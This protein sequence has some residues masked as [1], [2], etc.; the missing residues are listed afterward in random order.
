MKI[1]I[2]GFIAVL[3]LPV[4]GCEKITGNA[5]LLVFSNVPMKLS[6]APSGTE[7]GDAVFSPD[8]SRVAY[9]VKADGKET[10]VVNSESGPF[11]DSVREPVFSKDRL[12]I[13]YIANKGG[14]ECVVVDGRE[15]AWFDSIDKLM[16]ASD[17]RVVY[18][19]RRGEKWLVVSGS[20]ES[21]PF[22][23]SPNPLVISGDG[24]Q[25][26][27]AERHNDTKKSYIRSCGIDMTG[28]AKGKEYDSIV[29]ARLNASRSRLAYA[30]K[31]NDK[32]SVVTLDFNQ[33]ALR[34]T[35]GNWYDEVSTFGLSD[36]GKSLAF[37]A[38]RDEKTFLVKDG[39][40]KATPPY[41][42]AFDLEVSSNGHVMYTCLVE[43]KVLAF[44]DGRRLGKGYGGIHTITFSPD[45]LNV[46]Y[47]VESGAKNAIVVNGVEG[48]LL[49]KVVS[50]HFSPDG[51]RIFYRARNNGERF[52]VEADLQ[53]R[54]TREHP[55]YESVWDLVFSPDGRSVG[56][57]VKTG[58]EFWWKVEKL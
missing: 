12:G 49:D 13:A 50:P 58:Q 18:A 33:P 1:C 43:G 45:G 30:V 29:S 27:F 26:A 40:E 41:D 3:A 57:G 10:I 44:L 31:L 8:G 15:G 52:V 56:Y 25:L 5:K 35:E 37:L 17:G 6:T 42:T 53:G 46:T 11:Y 47:A 32:S 51:T 38:W 24:K 34:E 36:D 20:R 19:A 23:E 22:D 4:M 7:L 55:H 21:F 28:C 2:I 39:V 54:T 48:P 14:K 9:I 16:F